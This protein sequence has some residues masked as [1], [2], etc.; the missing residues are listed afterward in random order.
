MAEIWAAAVATVGSAY[1]SSRSS[2]RGQKDQIAADKETARIAAQEERS[3]MRYGSQLEDFNTQRGKERRLQA[4]YKHAGIRKKPPPVLGA[5]EP[6]MP[7]P[8]VDPVT[9][10]K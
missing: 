3:T 7:V 9:R 5:V 4:R 1:L 10:K 8:I 6:S 2:S